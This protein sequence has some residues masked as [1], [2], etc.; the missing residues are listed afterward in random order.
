GREAGLFVEELAVFRFDL[1]ASGCQSPA[2]TKARK[3]FAERRRGGERTKSSTSTILPAQ[4]SALLFSAFNS[5]AS[6]SRSAF[7]LVRVA[8]E[9]RERDEVGL[10][11]E[12]REGIGAVSGVWEWI[13]ARGGGCRV[14]SEPDKRGW[15]E[16]SEV[17]WRDLSST[18]SQEPDRERRRIS[19]PEYGKNPFP[20]LP[21]FFSSSSRKTKK[22]CTTRSHGKEAVWQ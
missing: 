14:G 3:A 20:L 16:A 18:S 12:E 2:L 1:R 11:D 4:S 13:E 8:E 15:R 10:G 7:L 9:E 21:P 19:I 6:A 22:R 17:F 5:A